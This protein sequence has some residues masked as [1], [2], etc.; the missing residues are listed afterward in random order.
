MQDLFQHGW[1]V[2]NISPANSRN[3]QI[4]SCKPT[5]LK[6]PDI[7]KTHLKRRWDCYIFSPFSGVKLNVRVVF[8]TVNQSN[9]RK[10]SYQQ[11]RYVWFPH[12]RKERS[13]E[14]SNPHPTGC[15]IPN[16]PSYNYVLWLFYLQGQ[17]NQRGGG[18][19]EGG[20]GTCLQTTHVFLRAMVEY[21]GVFLSQGVI[22][23]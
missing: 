22:I 8:D 6:S 11:K 21:N 19:G 9:S 15:T 5:I 4:S 17:G 2:Y 1:L 3:C 12:K 16:A 18:A 13:F 14:T 20:T 10:W 7:S 23:G